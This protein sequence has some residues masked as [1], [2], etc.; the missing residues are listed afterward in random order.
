MKKKLPGG[1]SHP[2]IP[3]EAHTVSVEREVC[4]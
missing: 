4:C 3:S 1:V 2:A